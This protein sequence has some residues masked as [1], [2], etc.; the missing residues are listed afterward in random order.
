[1]QLCETI[2]M[3]V[4]DV[5]N[6]IMQNCISVNDVINAIMWNCMPVNM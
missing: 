4:N 5:I 2:Y 1:M 6:T 3:P